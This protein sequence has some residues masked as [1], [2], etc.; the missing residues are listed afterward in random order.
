VEI[1]E[2]IISEA[3]IIIPVLW[4]LGSFLKKTPRI[5]DWLIPWVLLAVGVLIAVGIIGF[6]VDAAVQGVLV[7][8]AAVLGHQ[9]LK[10]TQ[11]R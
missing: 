4:I 1:I 7:A 9:L 6:T 5:E 8:G 2:Y 11:N 3:L 10:Q